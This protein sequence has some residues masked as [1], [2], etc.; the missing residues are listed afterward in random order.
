MLNF[1]VRGLGAIPACHPTMRSFVEWIH[2]LAYVIKGAAALRRGDHDG[3]IRNYTRAI[4]I[5][6]DDLDYYYARG[7]AY[8]HKK[9][10]GFAIADF[11][12]A[13]ELKP[14]DIYA[15]FVRGAIYQERGNLQQAMRDLNVVIDASGGLALAY[16]LRAACHAE[17]KDYELALADLYEVADRDP[18]NDKARKLIDHCRGQLHLIEHRKNA[19]KASRGGSGDLS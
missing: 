3:V 8:W 1:S 13:I 17:N 16:Y 7:H 9:E 12:K 15:H 19:E 4:E 6:P 11:S 2:S 5:S 10:L 18:A 14:D